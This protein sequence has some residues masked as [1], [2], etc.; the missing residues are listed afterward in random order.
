VSGEVHTLQTAPTGTTACHPD[1]EGSSALPRTPE[2]GPMQLASSDT[3]AGKSIGPSPRKE[4]GPQDDK[5][6]NQLKMGLGFGGCSRFTRL[7]KT[8]PDSPWCPLGR[9]LRRGGRPATF[10][11]K[12]KDVGQEC[13]THTSGGA[14]E[15]RSTVQRLRL[16]L[17]LA[18]A[19]V[20]A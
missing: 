4:R 18:W 5:A 1:E 15:L 13:P 6:D 20:P 8:C 19:A 12:V 2:E 11:T 10:P 9:K 3:T 17:G 14:V 16:R 7:D